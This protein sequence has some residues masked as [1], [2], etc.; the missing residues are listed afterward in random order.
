MIAAESY[1]EERAPGAGAVSAAMCFAVLALAFSSIFIKQLEQM[2]VP[3]LAIAFNRMALTTA[4]LLPVAIVWKR[5]EMT[6]LARREMALLALG[7]L[8]LA[9]HFGAWIT[10]L[11]YIPIATSVVL[12]NS[13]PFFVAIASYF[14]LGE[15]PTRRTIAGTSLGLVG[16][17]IISGDGFAGVE[18]ALWG[19]ILAII[20]A[21]AVVGYFIIGRRMRAKV[22]LL[23]YVTPL[24][25]VCTLFLFVWVLAAGDQVYPYDAT[26]WMYFIALAI[27]P[28]ILGHTVFNW[29]IKHVKTSAISLAFLGEP[30]AAAAL[31][32][33][34]FSQEPPMA[35]II[36]GALVLAGIY[37]TTSSSKSSDSA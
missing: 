22:S 10:S 15:K 25:G 29:A 9:A 3:P 6:T 23:G 26:A 11:K 1:K 30:V 4:L 32:F 24:Y 12:V 18:S 33:L 35:T 20:G 34:F 37:L 19:D 27:V 28:T 36:G 31:A 8:F 13:H 21:L 17:A 7:G 14:F 16:M 2:G 5:Q